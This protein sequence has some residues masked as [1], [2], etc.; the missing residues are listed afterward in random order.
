MNSGR[1]TAAQCSPKVQRQADYGMSF[2]NQD[3]ITAVD[4][5]N[6]GISL[7]TLP[8]LRCI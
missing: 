4:V 5:T 3:S 8:N 2:P 7:P 6:D 1:E